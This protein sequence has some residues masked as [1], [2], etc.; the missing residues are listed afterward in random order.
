M[1]LFRRRRDQDAAAPEPRGEHPAPQSSP[2]APTREFEPAPYYVPGMPSLHQDLPGAAD[3]SR[4]PGG[5]AD[6]Y[7][8]PGGADPVTVDAI[9]D[10][11]IDPQT[12][13]PVESPVPQ[14][15]PVSR[16]G[17][18]MPVAAAVGIGLLT[19]TVAAAWWDPL[20]F[21]LLAC[22]FSL[23]AVAEW[24]SVLAKQARQVPFIP[25]ALATVGFMVATWYDGPEGLVVALMVGCAGTVAWRVVDERIENTLAD[26]L[27][28]MLTLLW[29]P[30][31]A[32]FLVL[33]VLA[34]D[35]WHRVLVVIL[36]VAG[37]D[38]GGLFAGMLFGRHPMAPR[39]SPKKTWEG[40][41]G[42]IVLG[43]LAASVAAYFFYDGQWWIGALVGAACVVAAALGDLAESAVKRDIQ[44]KDMSSLLP[45]HGGIMDRI[46]SL[47]LAAPVAY[48]VFALLQGAV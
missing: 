13:R 28:S 41:A 35:G 8:G 24:R 31:L 22:L 40:F 14:V 42:G 38:S 37:A 18:N 45:G 33:L 16:G 10:P 15:A 48:V 44:V 26:S 23:A 2:W 12:P 39:V 9:D 29:I 5:A 32:A 6:A 46:D 25:V 19:L 36:A 43:T 17:R 20:A 1:S 3:A 21:T 27:A 34:D 47:L 30:F 11:R 4:Q 7:A